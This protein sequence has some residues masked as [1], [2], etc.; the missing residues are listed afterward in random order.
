[1]RTIL[2]YGNIASGKTTLCK[3]LAKVMPDYVYVCQD[4]I[5][6]EIF[7]EGLRGFEL[8]NESK[9]RLLEELSRADKVIY[10]TVG[11]SVIFKKAHDLVKKRGKVVYVKVECSVEECLVRFDTRARHTFTIGQR[12]Y[13]HKREDMR[14][15]MY[16]IE[17]SHQ[18]LKVD[19]KYDSERL[20]YQ[21][22]AERLMKS[23]GVPA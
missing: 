23:L 10:E 20:S 1:M 16:E 6:D 13:Q 3:K 11:R 14:A 2:V 17:E 9:K 4:E 12:L 19:Y 5:R 21:V 7:R 8:E 15:L 18:L 22:M